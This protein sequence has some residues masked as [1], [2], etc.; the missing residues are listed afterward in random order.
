MRTLSMANCSHLVVNQTG[1]R[2]QSRPDEKCEVSCGASE[3]WCTSPIIFDDVAQSL[4]MI[5][6]AEK[7]T[8][9]DFI[10]SFVH[11]ESAEHAKILARFLPLHIADY[12]SVGLKLRQRPS[13][14]ALTWLTLPAAF[15]S[16][17]CRTSAVPGAVH[18]STSPADL[19]SRR[20]CSPCTQ[21]NHRT[22]N[23]AALQNFNNL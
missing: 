12:E 13:S 11:T 7:I 17:R 15:R 1:E 21:H 5:S 23:Y 9:L 10:A 14:I 18:Q 19:N 20:L 2:G 22:R 6:V 4:Q 16:H 8:N 3:K